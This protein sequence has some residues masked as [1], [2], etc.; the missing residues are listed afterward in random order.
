[1]PW[2]ALPRETDPDLRGTL[3]DVSVGEDLAVARNDDSGSQRCSAIDIGTDGDDGRGNEIDNAGDVDACLNDVARF[4]DLERLIGTP[5]RRRVEPLR[6]LVSEK[7]TG[8]ARNPGDDSDEGNEPERATRST[9][10]RD[11]RRQFRSWY[12][13]HRCGI[14]RGE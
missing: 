5:R 13:W 8:E 10:R 3:D 2:F 14:G 9:T 7:G 4:R 12:T 11:R 6:Q 1:L